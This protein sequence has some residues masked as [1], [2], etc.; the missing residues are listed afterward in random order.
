MAEENSAPPRGE[1]RGSAQEGANVQGEAPPQGETRALG[2]TGG[3]GEAGGAELMDTTDAPKQGLSLLLASA[4]LISQGA[5]AR[6]FA[7]TFCG[8]PAILKQRFEKKYRHPTLDARLTS[9]RLHTEARNMVRAAKLGVA[10][11][12]LYGVEEG[13]RCIVMQRVGGRSVKD[14]FLSLAHHS[15]SAAAVAAATNTSADPPVST[16]TGTRTGAGTGTSQDRARGEGLHPWVAEVAAWMGEAIAKLHDGGMVHG[17]LTTSNMLLSPLPAAAAAAAS[18]ASPTPA[19]PAATPAAAV[20]PER[21]AGAAGEAAGPAAAAGGAAGA[22]GA[23]GA[24][25]AGRERVV[26]IDFGLSFNSTI[27][28]DKA[29]DLYVLERALI[30]LHSSN[31]DIMSAV[32]TSYRHHSR[33]WSATLNKLGQARQRELHRAAHLAAPAAAAAVAL[34]RHTQLL[35]SPSFSPPLITPRDAAPRSPSAGLSVFN[36]PYGGVASPASSAASRAESSAIN[37]AISG[38]IH[39]AVNGAVSSPIDGSLKRLF[40]SLAPRR[41]LSPTI[42][43]HKPAS[44]SSSMSFSP[45]LGPSNR[46][47]HSGIPTARNG[48]GFG[49]DDTWQNLGTSSSSLTN[50]GV[51]IVP[52][53]SAFVIERFGK[54]YKTLGSGIHLL[55]PLVDRIAYVHSLKE[56]AIPIPN[57]SAITKDNVS[58]QIDGVLYVRIVDPVQASYGVERPLYAVVQLAQTTMRSELGKITLDN[59]FEER[60]ILNTNIVRA[61]NEAGQA[62]GIECLRYEIRDISPP[63]GVR[64]AM[65]MQAEAERRRRAQVLESEGDRQANINMAEGRKTAVILESEAAMSDQMNRAK[66]EAEAIVARARASAEGIDVLARALMAEGATQAASLRVAEQYVAALANLAKQ[67]TTVLLPSNVGDPS[68]MVAQALAIYKTVSS[69]PAGVTVPSTPTDVTVSGDAV[70]GGGASEP[71]KAGLVGLQSQERDREV[72]AAS[73]ESGSEAVDGGGAG[74]KGTGFSLQAPPK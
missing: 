16:G 57:Q 62:W 8:R 45:L 67:G 58:I 14:L 37:G 22:A 41:G 72:G 54:Y 17:D 7:A 49:S 24:V 10:V 70:T 28:E 34:L 29:V 65:E 12:V 44:T 60:D 48:W 36:G 40:S 69:S 13:E 73:R 46:P 59:T 30:S 32:L 64:A 25:G 21:A 27:A 42:T 68:S 38:A 4:E 5:E 15:P 20:P 56:E 39:G 71:R 1:E 23:V 9:K 18:V 55:I 6:V 26:V 33:F 47:F 74:R 19:A 51:R 31:G 50:W 43:H 61:I 11:P 35:T 53:K 52:E 2:E 66:G 3:K 63:P